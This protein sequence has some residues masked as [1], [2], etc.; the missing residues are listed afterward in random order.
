MKV[1]FS[2]KKGE[3]MASTH[4]NYSACLREWSALLT[5]KL[6]PIVYGEF[7]L[8]YEESL[9]YASEKKIDHWDVF[10]TL[11][12]DIPNWNNKIVSA[13]SKLV[14]EKIP[15]I[16][17]ILK[18]TCVALLYVLSSVRIGHSSAPLDAT[19]PS[20]EVFVHKV[21]EI[22]SEDF[23]ENFKSF[24]HEHSSNRRREERMY[25][26][27][28]IKD[29]I[30]RAVRNLMNVEEI[31]DPYLQK[32]MEENVY[33]LAKAQDQQ[34]PV[35]SPREAPSQREAPSTREASPVKREDVR[36][37]VEL[38]AK[39]D[40]VEAELTEASPRPPAEEVDVPSEGEAEKTIH[41]PIQMLQYTPQL[42]SEE[43]GGGS[44]GKDAP[45]DFSRWAQD[46]SSDEKL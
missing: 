28:V 41:I 20:L 4:S 35:I 17:A 5:D 1:G 40:K 26:I 3:K 27:S 12:T 9:K 32:V 46:A 34:A 33:P 38:K 7:K 39:L 8:L 37:A 22:C 21:F 6:T 14:T 25:I 11:I 2:I 16:K 29:S 15:R 19:I 18:N 36:A 10:Y 45:F 13:K 23:A 24:D 31:L 30:T 42:G 43:G 44:D